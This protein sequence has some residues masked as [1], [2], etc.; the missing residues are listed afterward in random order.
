MERI[1]LEMADGADEQKKLNE[2]GI[3]SKR[4]V[5]YIFSDT[6]NNEWLKNWEKNNWI[7]LL[8]FWEEKLE[9]TDRKW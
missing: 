7:H 4:S 3:N 9:K 1:M 5:I 2:S 8:L 6:F